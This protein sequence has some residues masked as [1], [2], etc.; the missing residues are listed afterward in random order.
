MFEEQLWSEWLF[1]IESE[2]LPAEDYRLNESL[3]YLEFVSSPK[4]EKTAMLLTEGE[5]ERG[6][7]GYT[8]G[9][10]RDRIAT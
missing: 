4:G 2:D 5:R 10:Q 9:L 7:R 3:L 6:Q 8:V 1:K